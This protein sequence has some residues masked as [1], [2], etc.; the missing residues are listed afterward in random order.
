M[1]IAAVFATFR[2]QHNAEF[3]SNSLHESITWLISQSKM[4]S[5]DPV[6][7]DWVMGR[8]EPLKTKPDAVKLLKKLEFAKKF[9]DNLNLLLAKPLKLWGLVFFL[10]LI[11]LPVFQLDQIRVKILVV[12]SI[13]GLSIATA[14][15]LWETKRFVQKCLETK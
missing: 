5:S 9:P 6:D 7:I 8:L 15:A 13:S 2:L 14:W 3:L 10:S 1:A 11:C 4:V 12:S